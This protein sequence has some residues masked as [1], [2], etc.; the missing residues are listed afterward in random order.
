MKFEILVLTILLFLY[1]LL[2]QLE[3]VTAYQLLD[4]WYMPF[5]GILA[6]TVAMSTPAGGGIVFFPA[7]L[8]L[9]VP[10]NQ[11][12]A[13]SVGAQCVGMGVFGTYNWMKQDRGSINFSIV[14][15]SVLVGSITSIIT[16]LVYPI[17][18]IKPLQIIFS[19][20]GLSLAICV[21]ITLKSNL[22]HWNN[23][24]NW[25]FKLFLSILLIGIVG[26]MLVGYIGTGIDVL[27]F[28]VLTFLLK[29]NAYKSTINSIL[30]MGM[31]AFIP[32]CV[33]LFVLR[34]VPIHLWL[35]VLPGILMGARLGS[36]L[37]RTVG[38]KKV[39]IGFTFLLLAEFGMTL[40]KYFLK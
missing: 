23:S 20:F 2:I 33:H 36:W 3:V 28:F 12:V 16:L 6:A 34:D 38:I 27:M 30:T 8:L 4:A 37:N 13:F 31:T 40:F 15:A 19:L 25:D 7:L 29:A 11:T 5:V 18:E 32:F 24:Y 22:L 10:P 17:V 35:M 39:L 1:W 21:I 26:G 14:L 9:G